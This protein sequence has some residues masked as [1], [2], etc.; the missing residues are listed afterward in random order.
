M[1]ERD[2]RR[3]PARADVDDRALELLD[4]LEPAQAVLEE[5]S[6]R[7]GRVAQR[8]QAGGCNQRGEPGLKRG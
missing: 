1:R 2:P 6:P 4:E 3:A 7:L 8:G 5:N